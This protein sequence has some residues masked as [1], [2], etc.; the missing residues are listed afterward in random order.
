MYAYISIHIYYLF[1]YLSNVYCRS[2]LFWNVEVVISFGKWHP[3]T[4]SLTTPP[5]PSFH[6]LPG[7]CH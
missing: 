2:E 7:G 1:I 5:L 3:F 4:D 6:P